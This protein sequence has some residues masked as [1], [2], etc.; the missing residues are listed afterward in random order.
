[1]NN[2]DSVVHNTSSP[3]CSFYARMRASIAHDVEK[4]SAKE[5][6]SDIYTIGETKEMEKFDVPVM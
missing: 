1:M 2:S 6:P 4:K 3:K 5:P